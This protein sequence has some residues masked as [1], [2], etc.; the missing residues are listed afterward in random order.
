MNFSSQK[1][2]SSSIIVY[3]LGMFGFHS[4]FI[5]FIQIQQQFTLTLIYRKDCIISTETKTFVFLFPAHFTGSD[6]EVVSFE[7]K[8]AK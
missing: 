7:I 8:L 6:W 1:P 5:V 3:L 2:K 4:W